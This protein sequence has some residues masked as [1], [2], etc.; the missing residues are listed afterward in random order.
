MSSPEIEIRAYAAADF[1]PVTALMIE[2]QDFER[3]FT[4]YR[5]RADREFATWYFARLLR[6]LDESAGTLLVATDR[7]APCG[8]AA[9]FAEDEPEMRD[10]PAR[11]GE[12][13]QRALV[14][15]RVARHP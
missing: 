15:A 11:C 4:P 12:Q 3:R 8:Y 7:A 6:G 10:R 1:E 14:V 9:G 5:V 2:L 13:R